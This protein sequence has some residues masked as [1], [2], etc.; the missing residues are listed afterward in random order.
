[1]TVKK[2]L[3]FIGK[4]CLATAALWFLMH[5]TQLKL[6]LFTHLLHAPLLL[7]SIIALFFLMMLI[8]T[9]RWRTLNTAQGIHLN[10]L[11][12]IIPT[13]LGA[14]FNNLLPG[15]IGGDLVRL[16]YLFKKIPEKKS[17]ALLSILFDRITGLMG[18]FV[19]ISLLAIFQFR[20][21]TQQ[22]ELF[23]LFILCTAACA[24]GLIVFTTLL[25][26]PNKWWPQ[27]RW[28]KP[29][30]PL[31]E[32]IAIYRTNKLSIIKCLIMSIFIQLLIVSAII[33]IAKIMDLPSIPFSDYAIAMGVTQI[34]NLI[35][36]TPGGVG[37]GEIAFANILLLL[38][39]GTNAAYATTFLAYRLMSMLTYLPGVLCY[40]PSFQISA[41]PNSK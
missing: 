28:V 7:T 36:V 16:H 21:F 1:M 22:H 37:I 25:I 39:P 10:F 31:L 3:L 23:Y 13:Y 4:L 11:N 26:M 14:A 40:I 38:N 9:W 15:S 41:Y 35:P 34:V 2:S 24:S 6:E 29:F 20:F 33:L 8:N 18:I 30:L 27:A 17:G 5:T 32:A 12:T 19:I